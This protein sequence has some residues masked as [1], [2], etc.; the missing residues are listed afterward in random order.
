M[1]ITFPV[2]PCGALRLAKAGAVCSV[3]DRV[4]AAGLGDD[5][6]FGD[7]WAQSSDA[8]PALLRAFPTSTSWVGL[9]TG[10]DIKVLEGGQHRFVVACVARL[11]MC[12]A[13][14]EEC[15]GSAGARARALGLVLAVQHYANLHIPVVCVLRGHLAQGGDLSDAALMSAFGTTRTLLS[16]T[17][18]RGHTSVWY[19]SMACAPPTCFN[20][21]E[22]DSVVGFSQTFDSK[23]VKSR[24]L[25]GC[26]T[27][28]Q[29]LTQR[30]NVGVE[31][32]D[33]RPTRVPG[34]CSG[35]SATAPIP[36]TGVSAGPLALVSAPK[37]G[38]RR[39]RVIS[40]P[41]GRAKVRRVRSSVTGGHRKHC[42]DGDSD[43]EEGEEEGEGEEEDAISTA[44]E[45]LEDADDES[46]DEGFADPGE[47][48]R[49]SLEELL[50]SDGVG[51]A[52]SAARAPPGIDVFGN[53]VD[54]MLRKRLAEQALQ[55]AA[56]KER[57]NAKRAK[58]CGT[59]K[60]AGMRTQQSWPD[61]NNKP[62]A[63]P[64]LVGPLQRMLREPN[65]DNPGFV[66]R[67]VHNIDV[68]VL[69]DRAHQDHEG[70]GGAMETM[71]AAVFLGLTGGYAHE[72]NP[73]RVAC[74]PVRARL[75]RF[76]CGDT[77]GPR[78]TRWLKAGGK[79]KG[80]K[81]RNGELFFMCAMVEYL[82]GTAALRPGRAT[83]AF[84]VTSWGGFPLVIVAAMSRLR[85]VLCTM[86]WRLV[87]TRFMAGVL[88]VAIDDLVATT[89]LYIPH[90]ITN[91]AT[92]AEALMQI[93]LNMRQAGVD[94]TE[95]IDCNTVWVSRETG[96]RVLGAVTPE[97]RPGVVRV[98]WGVY[99][100]C[101]QRFG[102]TKNKHT[103][104]AELDAV[105]SS[106]VWAA[107]GKRSVRAGRSRF[108]M[109]NQF[110]NPTVSGLCKDL[111]NSI[112]A[113]KSVIAI[114]TDVFVR[115]PVTASLFRAAF[116]LLQ[117]MRADWDAIH[118]DDDRA[119]P[120]VGDV[121]A[122]AESTTGDPPG[123]VQP[124]DDERQQVVDL[125]AVGQV[126]HLQ[127]R[128]EMFNG[129]RAAREAVAVMSTRGLYTLLLLCLVRQRA[130]EVVIMPLP[131]RITE[132][133]GTILSV[134]HGDAVPHTAYMVPVCYA[135]CVVYAAMVVDVE[136]ENMRRFVVGANGVLCAPCETCQ[137]VRFLKHGCTNRT[138]G[139]S[140]TVA[141]CSCEV[142]AACR[143]GKSKRCSTQMPSVDLSVAVLQ[144]V[145]VAV[146]MCGWCGSRFRFTAAAYVNGSIA[147]QLCAD[148][149]A[150]NGA[151]PAPV[152]VYPMM[153]TEERW[154]RSHRAQLPRLCCVCTA[155]I[156]GHPGAHGDINIPVFV[157]SADRSVVRLLALCPTHAAMVPESMHGM[158]VT[159]QR[160]RATMRARGLRGASTILDHVP[161]GRASSAP[162]G[163]VL[164]SKAFHAVKA[165]EWSRL[166]VD[167]PWAVDAHLRDLIR[168]ASLAS[169]K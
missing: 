104:P 96:Q 119:R 144:I 137:D 7:L 92:R 87:D 149:A 113:S 36:G 26:Q 25:T 61:N 108:A 125:L 98:P 123:C 110:D 50:G 133:H 2:D 15:S 143:G 134:I 85:H 154:E 88:G 122:A 34:S 57:L 114:L 140:G 63:T 142:S 138:C 56:Q 101:L 47:D 22:L 102:F 35:P 93:I 135:C 141:F 33:T 116:L 103:V 1:G 132:T 165:M 160:L 126:F 91:S 4:V 3:F 169:V 20:A 109:A 106:F 18:G 111:E 12:D 157:D 53:K 129:V 39:Q 30:K 84:P 24:R 124:P 159:K 128:G 60:E 66:A 166:R 89:R 29:E 14:L 156:P 112:D 94:V 23:D 136:D 145:D 146:A 78:F 167:V 48:T 105:R 152:D 41:R 11:M 44:D 43:D 67:V 150:T 100:F 45:V 75:W 118:K 71:A 164:E 168:D 64:A 69:K 54:P 139:G 148:F 77:K 163:D 9:P 90:R 51:G 52:S 17:T 127:T 19:Q 80:A 115:E 155:F 158:P 81:G 6:L 151:L 59:A 27:S 32:G 62:A 70:V 99:F 121:A 82:V 28:C 46:V 10:F 74:F 117:G 83:T 72:C 97:M 131:R 161:R 55:N 68:A 79:I 49:V 8:F 5:T 76:L 95:G 37:R 58:Q 120:G 21:P 73:D 40:P 147:C 65:P 162:R 38:R 86:G 42:D 31:K 13:V 153:A 107:V 16:P 130:E